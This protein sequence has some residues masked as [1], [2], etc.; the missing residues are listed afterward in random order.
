M[1]VCTEGAVQQ[2]DRKFSPSAAAAVP[3]LSAATFSRPR[4]AESSG[5]WSP[6]MLRAAEPPASVSLQLMGV[7]VCYVAHARASSGR[8][9]CKAGGMR[10]PTSLPPQPRL[11]QYKLL[12]MPCSVHC[13]GPGRSRKREPK[14]ASAAAQS[15]FA[16]TKPDHAW[17]SWYTT[18]L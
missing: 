3:G 2:S 17:Q 7:R 14:Q 10:Q 4:V 18:S 11:G 9:C 8:P 5:A 6:S 13:A 12:R 16:P 15:N 1:R